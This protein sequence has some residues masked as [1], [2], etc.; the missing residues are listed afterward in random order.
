MGVEALGVD[1]SVDRAREIDP[2]GRYLEGGAERLPLPDA[3]VDVA[4]LMLSLHHVPDPDSAFPEL[5]RVVRE[6]VYIAEPLPT[7]DFFELMRP[8]DDETEVRAAAQAA[9]RRATGFEHVRTIEY[10]VTFPIPRFEDFRD[11]VLA[12]DP[13]R[14]ARFEELEPELRARFRPG[15]YVVPMRVDVLRH[16]SPSGNS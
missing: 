15:D 6:D 8:V 13:S 2:D 11:R 7:G 4:L 5:H 3:S 9:I 1:I 10:E 16:S 14:T 12:A